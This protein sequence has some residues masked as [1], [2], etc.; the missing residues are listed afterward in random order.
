MPP[1]LYPAPEQL[2]CFPPA[3][4]LATRDVL[5]DRGVPLGHDNPCGRMACWSPSVALHLLRVQ[6]RVSSCM[7]QRETKKTHHHWLVHFVVDVCFLGACALLLSSLPRHHGSRFSSS[8]NQVMTCVSSSLRDSLGFRANSLIRAAPHAHLVHACGPGC[9]A[10]RH[11][12]CRFLLPPS[13]A[14]ASLQACTKGR[15][16]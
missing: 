11:Q 7:Q 8:T 3:C 6:T 12:H 14:A 9:G 5:E 13:A 16:S 4:S 1:V 15:V 10:T 2:R